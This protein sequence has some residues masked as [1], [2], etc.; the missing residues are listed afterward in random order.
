MNQ[1]DEMKRVELGPQSDEPAPG[2]LILPYRARSNGSAA[3]AL[4]RTKEVVRA[5]ISVPDDQ[6]EDM[7]SLAQR[8]PQWFVGSFRPEATRK[9]EERWLAQWRKASPIDK[10]RLHEERGWELSGWCYWM[11]PEHRDWQWWR[12]EVIHRDEA[13]VEVA[14]F[15]WP[16][17]SGALRWILRSSGFSA[18][19]EN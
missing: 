19:E 4:D 13:I 1:S 8:F 10:H 6:W 12:S 14:V 11:E 2:L 15:E 16:F 17:A 9:E 7:Q 5:V 3:M 18:V